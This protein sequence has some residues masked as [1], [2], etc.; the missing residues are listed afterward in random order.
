MAKC[1][2]DDRRVFNFY[3]TDKAK[4][5]CRKLED[6]ANEMHDVATVDIAKKDIE[7]L[8]QL[9]SNIMGNLQDSLEKD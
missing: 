7:K 6:H 3:L 5:A 1:N 4:K 8:N 9:L 2:K